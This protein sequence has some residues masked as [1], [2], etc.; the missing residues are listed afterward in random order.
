MSDYPVDDERTIAADVARYEAEVD[1]WEHV[2]TAIDAAVE[3]R[4][5]V[6][7]LA[8]PNGWEFRHVAPHNGEFEAYLRKWEDGRF[9]QIVRYHR[10]PLVA[11]NKALEATQS[12]D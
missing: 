3:G 7:R 6:P 9:R 5:S 8:I 2:G 10:D 11:L 4:A 12:T 1:A